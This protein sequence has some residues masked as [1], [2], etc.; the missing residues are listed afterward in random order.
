[1]GPMFE[2][3][4]RAPNHVYP[5][6]CCLLTWSYHVIKKQSAFA[7]ILQEGFRQGCTFPFYGW[8][9]GA[10]GG[11]L[12]PGHTANEGRADW[13]RAPGLRISVHLP[14]T[15]QGSQLKP[16]GSTCWLLRALLPQAVP[17]FTKMSGVSSTEGQRARRKLK[18]RASLCP[19]ECLRGHPEGAWGRG[20]DP[21][22][23]GPLLL[24]A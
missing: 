5:L 13:S 14:T 17:S 3:G 20:K 1:M 21:H 8:G 7:S 23:E 19:G 22:P 6:L 10:Q 4:K 15:E 9:T 11:T 2:L 18:G 12:E 16:G 24:E